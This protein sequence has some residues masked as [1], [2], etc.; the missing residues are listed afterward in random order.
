MKSKIVVYVQSLLFIVGAFSPISLIADDDAIWMPD[1]ALHAYTDIQTAYISRG[2]VWDSRPI[3]TQFA[4]VETILGDFGSVDVYV[5]T[6]STFS[7][8]GHSTP[9][10]YAYNEFDYGIS[11]SYAWE[12]TEDW[13]LKNGVTR[14]WVTSPGVRGKWHSLIDWQAFQALE[15]PYVVPYWRLRAIQKPY[16]AAY[17]CVGA[18]KTFELTEALSFTIDFAGHLGNASH[19]RRMFGPDSDE[20]DSSWKAGIHAVTLVF[21][22]DY[23]LTDY[24]GLYAFVGQ[25]DIIDDDARDAVKASTAKEAKRDLTYGGVGVALDF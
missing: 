3:N 7:S 15:N 6:M 14:Q 23:R 21:R 17:W 24:L 19:F 2:Y 9:M 20:P 8:K 16:C 22:F 18:K 12:I 1:L 5:W 10:R 11:Y 13:R 25:L 4:D